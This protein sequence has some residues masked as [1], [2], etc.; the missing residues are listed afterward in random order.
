[1]TEIQSILLDRKYFTIRSA[2]DWLKQHN[3]KTY[4]L[5]VTKRFIRARQL[6]PTPY[7]R[8]R[9]IDFSNNIK[10]VIQF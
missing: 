8:Y 7:K 3:Y 1:M 10:A 9:I 6:P 4:K 2:Y 5:D